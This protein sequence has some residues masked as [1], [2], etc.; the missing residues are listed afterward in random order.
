MDSGQQVSILDRNEVLKRL[1]GTS[2]DPGGEQAPMILNEAVIDMLKDNLGIGDNEPAKKKKRGPKVP[3]G[4]RIT[5]LPEQTSSKKDRGKG[6][7]HS[8]LLQPSQLGPSVASDDIWLCGTCKEEWRLQ[9]MFGFSVI[10]AMSHSICN[11]V[12]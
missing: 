3:A 7:A 1:P 9:E 2:Q 11:V 8:N 10:L 12:G 6:K 5:E 4:K